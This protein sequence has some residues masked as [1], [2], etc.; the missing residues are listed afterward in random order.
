MKSIGKR[1]LLI[2]SIVLVVLFWV[3]QLLP[4]VNTTEIQSQTEDPSKTWAELPVSIVGKDRMSWPTEIKYDEFDQWAQE[5]QQQYPLYGEK[6]IS[7]FTYVWYPAGSMYTHQYFC[8]V[9][10]QVLMIAFILFAIFIKNHM[11][12]AVVS[13][14]FALG[15][16]Y[17]FVQ[18]LLLKGEAFINPNMVVTYLFVV[19]AVAAIVVGVLNIPEFFED[20]AKNENLKTRL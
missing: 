3:V 10:A 17:A 19:L 5:I 12:K 7:V 16:I 14:I 20:K 9:L 11:A 2:S 18:T 6:N 8:F 13:F 1:N 15:L 4:F